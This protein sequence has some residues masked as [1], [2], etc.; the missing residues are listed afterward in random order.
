MSSEINKIKTKFRQKDEKNGQKRQLFEKK[1]TKR[2]KCLPIKMSYLD[3]TL[4]IELCVGVCYIVQPKSNSDGKKSAIL[5][6]LTGSEVQRNKI[7]EKN[8]KTKEETK[9]KRRESFW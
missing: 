5:R 8:L 2:S 3:W 4:N 1:R 6:V 7:W 9:D